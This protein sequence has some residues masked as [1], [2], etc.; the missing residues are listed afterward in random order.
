MPKELY[1]GLLSGTSMDG[2]DAALID[3][4]A[5]KQSPQL[6]TT[7]SEP[8]PKQL[9]QALL[10]L[11]KPGENG[12]NR[13]G[14]ADNELGRLFAQCC[15]QLI[16][17]AKINPRE[18]RAIGS[19]GQ[20]IRHVP[21]TEYPFTLQIGDPNIIAAMTGITT[22]ADF[23]RRDMAL[24]GQ[25]APLAPAFHNFLLRTSD[26][27]R[28]VLNIGGIAN[29]TYLAADGN[30]AILGFD[31][32]PGNTLSDAWCF[33]QLGKPYDN[34]GDWASSG[35]INPELLSVLLNDPYFQ[36]A[37]PKST[38]REYFNLDWLQQQLH[39]LSSRPSPEDIQA[40]LLELTARSITNAIQSIDNRPGSIWVCGGGTHNQRLMARLKNLCET[41]RVTTTK[42]IGLS[43]D[44]VEA[45]CFAWLA[46]QTL[47]GLPGNL[48][49]VT[50]AKEISVLGAIYPASTF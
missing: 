15:L 31:T 9:K 3:F 40:T 10:K 13:M 16:K 8:I 20:T 25:A 33:D 30:A 19:H 17:K 50:G 29:V 36:A 27:N 24:G 11:C 46:Q 26:E 4:D 42:E 1:I 43:P 44:W 6:V 45:M 14:H 18:I 47:K 23:R 22:V 41:H 2:V 21:N 5:N 39:S 12:I 32:G 38:G 37:P 49:S 7:Y 48:P 35:N 28:W 34:A